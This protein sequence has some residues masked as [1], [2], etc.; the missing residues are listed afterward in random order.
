MKNNGVMNDK[1]GDDDTREARWQWKSDNQEETDQDVADKV[2]EDVDS[3]G[4]WC[5]ER[6]D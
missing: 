4:G 3:K 6:N 5:S 1:S 2:S